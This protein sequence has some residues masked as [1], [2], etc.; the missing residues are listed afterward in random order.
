ML[1]RRQLAKKE[2]PEHLL[3]PL[4]RC[5]QPAM[6]IC[7]SLAWGSS[8]ECGTSRNLFPG[9]LVTKQATE[10][11][12]CASSI[13]PSKFNNP[14]AFLFFPLSVQDF[15][16]SSLGRQGLRVTIEPSSPSRGNSELLCKLLRQ[17]QALHDG[18]TRPFQ[19]P[20]VEQAKGCH[21]GKPEVRANSEAAM[22]TP[23]QKNCVCVDVR[24]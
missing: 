20:T 10:H 12:N 9:P 7:A 2:I 6:L 8:R 17:N 1:K 13:M 18:P 5:D 4:F 22:L 24:C 16:G 19:N 21:C 11:Q 15:L 23:Q 14:K 3:N